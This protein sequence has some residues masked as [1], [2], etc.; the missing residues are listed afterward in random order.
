MGDFLEDIDTPLI[1]VPPMR[2]EPD[3][4]VGSVLLDVSGRVQNEYLVLHNP[5][6][7]ILRGFKLFCS[8][9]TQ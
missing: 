6:E 3:P 2:L 9:C 4:T 5:A 8:I 1:A 7:P